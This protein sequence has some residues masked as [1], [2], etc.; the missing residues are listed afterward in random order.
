MSQDIDNIEDIKLLEDRI[1]RYL[2]LLLN[3]RYTRMLRWRKEIID[4]SFLSTVLGS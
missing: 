3:M 2:P 4:Q 1:S